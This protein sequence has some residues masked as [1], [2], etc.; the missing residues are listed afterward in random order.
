MALLPVTRQQQLPD[1]R[2]RPQAKKTAW[3]NTISTIVSTT[4]ESWLVRILPA[5]TAGTAHLSRRRRCMYSNTKDLNTIPLVPW[6][7]NSL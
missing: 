6:D 7:T 1:E 4:V 3:Y 2:Q 5:T